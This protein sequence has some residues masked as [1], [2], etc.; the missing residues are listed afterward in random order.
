MRKITVCKA[1]KGFSFKASQD[2]SCFLTQKYIDA[3][4]RFVPCQPAASQAGGWRGIASVKA[5]ER[6]GLDVHPNGKTKS[7]FLPLA[8]GLGLSREK[9]NRVHFPPEA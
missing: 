1:T 5:K 7:N 6:G 3:V 8:L 9:V 4:H 2:A